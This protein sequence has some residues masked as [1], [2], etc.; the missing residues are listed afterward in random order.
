MFTIVIDSVKDIIGNQGWVTLEKNIENENDHFST[1][2]R[3]LLSGLNL[4]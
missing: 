4:S 2:F 3:L 1:T